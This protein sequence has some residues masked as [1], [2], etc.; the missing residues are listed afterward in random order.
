[1]PELFRKYEID[2]IEKED[3]V[4]NNCE[5]VVNY[6]SKFFKGVTEERLYLLCLDPALR[7]LCFEKIS[8]GTVNSTM[9]NNRKIVEIAYKYNAANLILVHNHPSGVPAPSKYDINATMTTNELLKSLGMKLNDHI[10]L[11]SSG[12]GFF[13]FRRNEKWKGLF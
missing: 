6:V 5:A 7:V 3:E 4:L 8:E 13:S 9:V 10:I 11:G 2:K 1:M 12:Q